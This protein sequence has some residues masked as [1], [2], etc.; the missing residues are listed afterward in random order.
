MLNKVERIQYIGGRPT[1]PLQALDT[2]TSFKTVL[3]WLPRKQTKYFLSLITQIHYNSSTSQF[4][5]QLIFLICILITFFSPYIL[6]L[7]WLFI[8]MLLFFVM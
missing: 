8:L 5:A 6:H 4:S 7:M 2:G 3:F 1:S